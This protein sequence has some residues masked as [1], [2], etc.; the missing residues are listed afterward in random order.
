MAYGAGIGFVWEDSSAMLNG[1]YSAQY[2]KRIPRDVG[3]CEAVL[4]G[5]T[6]PPGWP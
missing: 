1:R 2:E 5:Y 6:C 4:I 3:P